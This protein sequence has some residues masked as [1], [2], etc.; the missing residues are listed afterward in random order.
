MPFSG[1]AT[2][3]TAFGCDDDAIIIRMQGF[4]DQ[5]FAY[6]GSVGVGC[7]DEIYV[8]FNDTAKNGA[9]FFEVIRFAPD[10]SAGNPHRAE[11]HPVDLKIAA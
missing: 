8:Q 4:S 11:A 10:A 3:E 2:G 9:G 5:I 1:T 6:F 7:V